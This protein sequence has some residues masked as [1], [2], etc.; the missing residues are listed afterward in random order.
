MVIKEFPVKIINHAQAGS[1]VNPIKDTLKMLR[2]VNRI[3]KLHKN[4]GK[5]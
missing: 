1:K 3:K 2:D 4:F 5:E